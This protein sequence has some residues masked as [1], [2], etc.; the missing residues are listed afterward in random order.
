VLQLKRNSLK[1]KKRTKP[2][3]CVCVCVGQT[4]VHSVVGANNRT[5]QTDESESEHSIS[6]SRN[7][8]QLNW[9]ISLPRRIRNAVR[10]E[11][12]GEKLRQQIPQNNSMVARANDVRLNSTRSIYTLAVRGTIMR[13][14][15]TPA[16]QRTPGI[17]RADEK[18][19]SDIV[20]RAPHDDDD[21]IN[22][23]CYR[24]ADNRSI[25]KFM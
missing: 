11:L 23:L 21:E 17:R 5:I 3:P 22:V 4:R 20:V 24:Q 18:K 15:I 12:F 1:K 9:R 8:T 13:F 2:V 14:I 7:E 16:Q 25:Y 10:A 6:N 19:R